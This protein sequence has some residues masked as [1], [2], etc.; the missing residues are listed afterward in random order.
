MVEIV[1]SAKGRVRPVSERALRLGK[2]WRGRVFDILL[3]AGGLVFLSPVMIATALAIYLED[4]GPILFSQARLGFA[5][6]TFRCFKFRSMCVDAEARLEALL[7]SS[8]TAK[9]QW[10]R[11]H[12][13]KID[14]RITAIGA[15]LRKF[16]L[17]ELPQLLNV[18]KG[19]MTL[20]GPRPIIQ[21]E[22]WRYGRR[23]H[24]Y[25]AVKPGL[26]GLWQ[27]SGR[28]DSTYR[29]RVAMDVVY[30]RRRGPLLDLKILAATIPAVISSRGSY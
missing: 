24:Y 17:D 14:P 7:E 6:K 20:V 27:I 1:L 28:S 3:S 12:K 21:A 2:S 22:V 30:S 4:G 13:L 19:D 10:E 11:D 8:P 23:F 9:A 18:L 25:C 15:I 29:A 16:S 5:G 26:T